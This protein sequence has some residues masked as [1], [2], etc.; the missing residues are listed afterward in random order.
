MST[1]PGYDDANAGY[2][3]NPN[4][5]SGQFNAPPNADMSHIVTDMTDDSDVEVI[6]AVLGDNQSRNAQKPKKHRKRR[7]GAARGRRKKV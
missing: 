7:T 1:N 2:T 6:E 5:D 3:F 4:Q